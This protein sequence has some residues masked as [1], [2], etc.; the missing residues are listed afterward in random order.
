MNRLQPLFDWYQSLPERDARLVL[1]TAAL[2]LATGFYVGLW[3]PVHE[4]LQAQQEQYRSQRKIHD[5]M[6]N[7]A[8][9]ARALRA[10]GGG[11]T[12]RMAD[13]PVNLV[14]E[15]TLATSGLKKHVGK[16]ESAAKDSARVKLENAGFDQLLVWLNTIATHNGIVVSS[17][18]IE[19][20]EKSGT[21]NA[22]LSL[23]RP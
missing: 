7:A 15:Q 2:L 1:F 19:R 17:A 22:R 11:Q 9:E 5:W 21:V 18:S 6:Q 3:A 10:G 14:L 8:A 20:A 16:L 13:K 12:I 23:T 4:H